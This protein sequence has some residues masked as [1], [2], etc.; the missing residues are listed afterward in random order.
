MY[1]LLDFQHIFWE[2]IC[3]IYWKIKTNNVA[4][5]ITA[6]MKVDEAC[7][8]IKSVMYIQL[9]QLIQNGSNSNNAPFLFPF[10]A[11]S[12]YGW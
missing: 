12:F 4:L 10:I 11:P 1:A 7:M 5:L 2:G 8:W 3:F 9:T 6:L